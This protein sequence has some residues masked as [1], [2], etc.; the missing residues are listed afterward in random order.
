MWDKEKVDQAVKQ[1]LEDAIKLSDSIYAEPELA[2]HEVKSSQKIVKLLRKSG[3][4]VEYPFLERELGYPTAFRATLRNGEG[5]AVAILVE[6]D[7]LPEI[8]HACG[9]NLHGSM[10]TLAGMALAKLTDWFK[11]T[12][13][14]IGTPAEEENGAKIVMEREKVFEGLSLAAMIHSH[15][16]GVSQTNMDVLSLRCYEVEFFGQTAHAVAGPWHGHSALAAARKFLDLVDARRECFT[17]DVFV[18]AIIQDGGKSPNIIPDYAKL[19]MEFRT[20]SRGRLE[21][22]DRTIRKCGDA[23]AM[24]LDCKVAYIPGLQDFW[25]MV[26]VTPLEQKA[27][28]LM[29]NR[30]EKVCDPATACGSSD[31][32][33]VSYQ[34]PSIQMLLSISDE[35]LPLHTVKMREATKKEKAYQQ[36]EKG[37]CLLAELALTALNDEKFRK[38]VLEAFQAERKRK[39]EEA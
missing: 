19:R 2:Y 5:P 4:E 13:Y 11:G 23:A 38:E 32:G 8:G 26:R 15:S 27:R 28:E 1:G 35:A 30:G 3:Y 39:D 18:N 20:S 22:M 21:E 6:Y 7:A 17:P 34:C 37:G 14:L 36:L 12:V 16:G 29:E 33:N 10:A 31:M 25:D 9:H 24:A